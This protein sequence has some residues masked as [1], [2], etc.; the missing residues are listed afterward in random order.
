MPLRNH[1]KPLIYLNRV[2]KQ[3]QLTT[4]LSQPIPT[5]KGL[6]PISELPEY[7]QKLIALGRYNFPPIQRLNISIDNETP[8]SQGIYFATEY[9]LFAYATNSPNFPNLN[10]ATDS[11]IIALIDTQ[12]NLAHLFGI[13]R[14]QIHPQRNVAS[15]LEIMLAPKSSADIPV[16]LTSGL[17]N[18]CYKPHLLHQFEGYYCNISIINKD[19][20]LFEKYI[21]QTR[22]TTTRVYCDKKVF[23][24]RVRASSS[25]GPAKH[26][27][28]F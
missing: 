2:I 17:W 19:L 14:T 11:S 16:L 18:E 21:A 24:F 5:L 4:A 1:Y 22:K 20:K 12:R 15:E 25:P 27:F 13:A 9:Y 23:C 6:H 8:V 26:K 3:M 28:S 10:Y 7:T